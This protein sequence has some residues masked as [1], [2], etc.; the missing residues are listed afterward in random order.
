MKT[1]IFLQMGIS[2]DLIS[3]FIVSGPDVLMTR[4]ERI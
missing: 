2:P 4:E 3:Q 1:I